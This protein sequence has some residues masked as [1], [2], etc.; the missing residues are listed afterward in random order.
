MSLYRGRSP[1]PAGSGCGAPSVSNAT[2]LNSGSAGGAPVAP[3][4]EFID[5][6]PPPRKFFLA[7]KKKNLHVIH[8]ESCACCRYVF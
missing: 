8:D 2:S 1:S 7:V 4:G 5:A 6:L 3:I